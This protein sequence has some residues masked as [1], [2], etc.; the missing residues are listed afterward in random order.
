MKLTY[1][2]FMNIV[3]QKTKKFVIDVIKNY[4]MNDLEISNYFGEKPQN[5]ELV[6]SLTLLAMIFFIPEDFTN[7]LHI[8]KALLIHDFNSE[9]IKVSRNTHLVSI[10][11]TFKNEFFSKKYFST[12]CNLFCVSDNIYDYYILTPEKIILN[13]VIKIRKFLARTH[14]F[15]IFSKCF[16]HGLT[17]FFNEYK[18][19]VKLAEK[20]MIKQLKMDIFKNLSINAISYLET[21]VTAH[22]LY[23]KKYNLNDEDMVALSLLSSL[24]CNSNADYILDYFEYLNITKSKINDIQQLVDVSKTDDI[25]S[26]IGIL[27][28]HYSKFLNK[29]GDNQEKIYIHDILENLL[30]RNISNSIIIEKIFNSLNVSLDVFN[31]FDEKI[32]EFEIIKENK[33]VEEIYK[34]PHKLINYFE[35]LSKIYDAINNNKDSK[36]NYKEIEI[37]S[38]AIFLSQLNKNNEFVS[39]FSSMDVNLE[40]CLE[41][42]NLKDV[43]IQ[44]AQVNINTLKIIYEKLSPYLDDKNIAIKV[45]CEKFFNYKDNDNNKDDKDNDN[46][47]KDKVIIKMLCDI[48]EKFTEIKNIWIDMKKFLDSKEMEKRLKISKKFYG[49]LPV[50][51]IKYIESS[52]I[53]YI[54]LKN[55]LDLTKGYTDDDIVELSLLFTIP[56]HIALGDYI[57]YTLFENG[58]AANLD[59]CIC[60]Y[61]GYSREQVNN[62]Y[63]EKV[64]FNL[65]TK[66][67]GKYIF[68]GKNKEKPKDKITIIDI[69]NNLFN[70]ELND[71]LILKNI[72]SSYNLTYDDFNDI[73]NKYIKHIEKCFGKCDFETID[74][75][76][77]IFRI[78]KKIFS[79]SA[80]SDIICTSFFIY[81]LYSESKLKNYLLDRGITLEKI[82][83][84]LKISK[85]ELDKYKELNTDYN[86]IFSSFPKVNDIFKENLEKTIKGIFELQNIGLIHKIIKY[87]N[88]DYETVKY[89][90]VNETKYMPPL[91]KEEQLEQYISMP[92][93]KLEIDQIVQISDFGSLLTEQS[94]LITQEFSNFMEYRYDK[95]ESSVEIQEAIQSISKKN[96]VPKK[97]KLFNFG[98]KKDEIIEEEVNNKKEILDKLRLFL[99]ERETSLKKGIEELQYIKK[100]IGV[101]LVKANEYLDNLK[102]AKQR[103]LEEIKTRN[104]VENDFRVYDDDLKKQLLED[105][106]ASITSSIVQMLQQYQKMTIQM[107]T[108]AS[109]LNQ[110]NLA[111]NTTIQRLYTELALKEGVE[112]EKE[113][114]ESLNCLINILNN[115][116]ATNEENMLEN[117]EKI[118]K[119]SK[120]NYNVNISENDKLIM[121]QILK[122]Q[123]ML[124]IDKEKLKVKKIV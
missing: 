41:Y 87:T 62:I 123:N 110:V 9:D 119:I 25:N 99:E 49:D 43:D 19:C 54:K 108:H 27:I 70:K 10:S 83:D 36:I 109:L 63:D 50:D 31:N 73:E 44:N 102:E 30:D 101:F 64:D 38:L 6:K 59:F 42:L 124:T 20:E 13:N 77:K 21:V 46:T 33:L 22:K 15:T 88:N 105:K 60:I 85:K 51:V 116:T 74:N 121:E 66:Y 17:N 39:Y 95:E 80:D 52:F 81:L 12:L 69:L 40:Q 4:I 8:E 65:L 26:D 100:S 35:Y 29:K 111:R 28:R 115:M 93:P 98:K 67:Y 37:L 114:I 57:L 118:N 75:V 84:Y 47:D 55:D 91:T 7:N 96:N 107:S 1:D 45:L 61:K 92:I 103:L 97:V 32:K 3:P 11:N 122:E 34:L 89:E 53:N 72:L 94:E 79:S 58:L 18:S 104:Y 5:E 106:I 16:P 48:N 76:F 78:I 56:E 24:Y 90:I 23:S 14:Y 86:V 113:S 120:N 71:S 68:G 82:A 117:I 2:E 112:K